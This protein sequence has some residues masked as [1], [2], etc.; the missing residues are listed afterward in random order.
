MRNMTKHAVLILA[1][2]WF[3]PQFIY[4]DDV[5]DFVMSIL[6]GHSV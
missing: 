2:E 6:G 1:R 4:L 3:G 5:V